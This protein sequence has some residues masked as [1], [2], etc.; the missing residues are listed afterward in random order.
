MQSLVLT[1][2]AK[3]AQKKSVEAFTAA[4]GTSRRVELL[5]LVLFVVSGPV[6]LGIGTVTE[7][8]ALPGQRWQRLE[9]RRVDLA[10]ATLQRDGGA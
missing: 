4:G 3:K 10:A 8:G 2:L 6:W 1:C 5:F 7:L 9:V